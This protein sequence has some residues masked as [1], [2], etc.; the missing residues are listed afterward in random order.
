MGL[1]CHSA[2]GGMQLGFCAQV[3]LAWPQSAAVLF[4]EIT[5]AWVEAMDQVRDVHGTSGAPSSLP[6]RAGKS[7]Q[8]H[9]EREENT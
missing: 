1:C 6:L 5:A 3:A 2:S 7:V 4:M 8:Q 9:L